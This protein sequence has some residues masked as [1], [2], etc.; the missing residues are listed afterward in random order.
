MAWIDLPSLEVSASE[1]YYASIDRGS[2]RFIN[3]TRTSTLCSTSTAT[4]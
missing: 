3:G 4:A 2:V 1:Q